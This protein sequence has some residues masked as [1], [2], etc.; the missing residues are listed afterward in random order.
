MTAVTHSG[1]WV[2]SSQAPGPTLCSQTNQGQLGMITDASVTCGHFDQSDNMNHQIPAKAP[3]I[4]Q[5]DSLIFGSPSFEFVSNPVDDVNVPSTGQHFEHHTSDFQFH[6]NYAPSQDEPPSIACH[7]DFS[8]QDLRDLREPWSLMPSLDLTGVEV[9]PMSQVALDQ[10]QPLCTV[11][12][13]EIFTDGSCGHSSD[14]QEKATWAFTIF[15]KGLNACGDPSTQWLGYYAGHVVDHVH[16]EHEAHGIGV[17]KISPYEAERSA[18]WWAAAYL[19]QSEHTCPM[20]LR[21]D[22]TAAGL[23][24]SGHILGAD[25]TAELGIG[26]SLRGLH[27]Y[28]G[29][30]KDVSYRHVKGHTGQAGNELA[31]AIAQALYH[32]HIHAHIPDLAIS[33]HARTARD[34]MQWTFAE[35]YH[36]DRPILADHKIL[37]PCFEPADAL[38]FE[39]RPGEVCRPLSPALMA[40][41]ITFV[42]YNVMTTQRHG[43]IALLRHHLLEHNVHVA[44]FQETRDKQSRMWPSSPFIRFCA[45]ATP[46]GEGGLQLWV[47]TD[48][49]FAT[50]QGRPVF[51]HKSQ[52][53]VAVSSH[54]LLIV[55]C[56]VG[57]IHLS[58]IV[59]HAPH[60]GDPDAP[61]WWE[62]FAKHLSAIPRASHKIFLLDANSRMNSFNDVSCGNH[63]DPV[64]SNHQDQSHL[65]HE[66]L[67]D[68]QMRLP[69]TFS[70]HHAGDNATWSIGQRSGSRLDYIAVP[71]DWTR[72]TLQSTVA[73][74]IRSGVTD[75]DHKAVK[76]RCTMVLDGSISKFH[77]RP[78]IDR[79]AM[80]TEA[81]K[82]KCRE[83]FDNMPRLPASTDPTIQCHVFEQF[84]TQELHRHFRLNRRAKKKQHLSDTTYQAVL[85]HRDA[86]RQLRTC[87]RWRDNTVLMQCFQTWAA[88]RNLQTSAPM[89][90]R[91]AYATTIRCIDHNIAVLTSRQ[92]QAHL[93]LQQHLR[94]DRRQHT[95]QICDEIAKAPIHDV[96][97]T[98]KPLLPKHRRGLHSAEHLPGL[99]DPAG[100][101]ATSP[102]EIAALFQDH[103]AAAEGGSQ[104]HPDDIVQHFMSTQKASVSAF[105]D[106]TF[107]PSLDHLPTLQALERKFRQI[108]P[109]KA[110]GP[111]GLPGDLFRSAPVE[112]ARA[113]HGLVTKVAL[114]GADPLQWRGGIVKAIYKRGPTEKP[115]SW[116][117]ILLSSIP[118][119]AAHSLL[120]EALNTCFQRAA[121][122]GQFGG[123]AGASI[124]VPTMGVRSFQRWCKTNNRSYA[125]IFVD[126]I[127]AFYR[128]IRELCFQFDD[129]DA[130]SRSLDRRGVSSKL[131]T[132]ILENAANASALAQS[133]AS[134]HLIAVT[135]TLHSITW[136]ICEQER[137]RVA[138]TTQGSRPGDPIADVLFNLIMSRAMYQIEDKLRI[139]GLL[140][141]FPIDNSKPLP[142]H[143]R[144]KDDTSF[145]GQAWVDDLIFMT[146]SADPKDLCD[147]ASQIVSIVQQELATMGIEMNLAKGKSEAIIHLAG[148]G[149]RQLRRELHLEQGS[150]IRFE[151]VDGGV[152]TLATSHRYK[153]LGSILSIHG[154]CTGDIKHRAAQT[155]ATLKLVRQSIFRNHAAHPRV[156]QHVL[157]AVILSKMM[158]TSGS[159]IF[160]TKQAEDCFTKTIMRIYKF[161]FAQLPGWKKDGHYTH[162]EV[163]VTLGALWPHELLHVNRLRGFI[164]AVQIGTPHIWALLHA[165]EQW[166]EH[167]REGLAWVSTQTSM[168]VGDPTPPMDLQAFV[169]LIEDSPQRARGL[170][171]RAQAA[172]L[173]MRIRMKTAHL[174]HAKFTQQL[175]DAG[176][177]H[178]PECVWVDESQDED[179]GFLCPTCGKFFPT[180]QQTATHMMRQHNIH[181][182]HYLWANRTSCLCCMQEF[183]TKRRLSAHFQHGGVRCLET[184]KFRYQDPDCLRDDRINPDNGHFPFAPVA[185]PVEPWCAQVVDEMRGWQHRPRRAARQPLMPRRQR[186]IRES[187][188]PE[189]PTLLS[190][191]ARLPG[192][193]PMPVQFILHFF[194]GRRRHND[195]QTFVESFAHG[196]AT[197][198]YVLSLDVAVDSCLGDLST[199]SA[200][201][202]WTDKAKRGYI[203]SFLSGPPCETFTRSR[204]R[205]GGPPP[206]RSRKHRWGLPG[207]SKRFHLQVESGNFLWRFTTSMLACQLAQGKGGIFEHPAPYDIDDGPCKG[208]IHTWAFPEMVAMAQWPTLV[209]H[210]VDQGC[211]GQICRKPTG[212][213]VLNHHQ[214]AAIFHD[215]M[216]PQHMWRLQGIKMGWDR[217][218][219]QFAT[220]PLKEYP[221]QL[222]AALAK[223]LLSGLDSHTVSDQGGLDQEHFDSFVCTTSH[224]CRTLDNREWGSMRP[225]WFRG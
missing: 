70:Q 198:V 75:S 78:P 147:R 167:V 23:S 8:R 29:L 19:L 51:F 18:L 160:D 61:A 92:Q 96:W 17:I 59:G 69:S 100:T 213:M 56:H 201:D 14:A 211:F 67:V 208:G 189:F 194:S 124:H 216:L 156:R 205:E 87:Y 5:L 206:L 24:A 146:S 65:F 120:R 112:A 42:S 169:R 118:G 128:L 125:L 46:Q 25:A 159:W 200:L 36:H 223:I 225:D 28:L 57:G 166:L 183:H 154:T 21:Y 119:K 3:V 66:V 62:E 11:D 133:H 219:K 113:Y 105:F 102:H 131:K 104:H 117:N 210:V 152:K 199:E 53:A 202:F 153:Y 192:H 73:D 218:N 184:L 109:N 136:F 12:T 93:N 60:S 72:G 63:G 150:M 191:D 137:E 164:A 30:C 58:F 79:C 161:V 209:L 101:A 6:R 74:S 45:A 37:F 222:N 123:K 140:E 126:G 172:A 175:L 80:S 97:N 103:F 127:E 187:T 207:L 98:L 195:L 22:S 121:H 221:S 134:D 10:C 41:D 50:C 2:P 196:L 4:L 151:D 83:I 149:S 84:L 71:C 157:H 143:C 180:P 40:L 95:Q 99:K 34:F 27:Q 145:C 20:S 163:I 52:F 35:D 176:F 122:P 182:D 212:F 43:T 165:D 9:H 135:R 178:P 82:S 215:M 89:C 203:L 15:A 220:A 185:G 115:S 114:F 38:P 49:P 138:L 31:D 197:H 224:L 54:R 85:C 217:S 141:T 106:G 108:R 186:Q 181:A 177:E 48:R 111:D 76:L 26:A 155:F 179:E 132:M 7:W 174:W 64:P 1:V 81:G 193:I 148:P 39:W 188:K 107:C 91:E 47:S 86:R 171:R 32:D 130:F 142:F 88:T 77:R 162:E 173:N 90:T 68:H 44:G 190:A 13:I 129:Y 139:N 204:F 158:A 170:L 116:R 16:I 55:H 144:G 94:W 33:S 214:A 110:S 168:D